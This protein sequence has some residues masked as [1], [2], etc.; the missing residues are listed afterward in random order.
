MRIP[1]G[2]TWFLLYYFAVVIYYV[3]VNGLNGLS[4]GYHKHLWQSPQLLSRT[5]CLQI[6]RLLWFKRISVSVFFI[7]WIADILTTFSNVNPFSF[8]QS[9]FIPL[10][11]FLLTIESVHSPNRAQHLLSYGT[12]KTC[13]NS[14]LF[15]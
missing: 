9:I 5:Q 10:Q 14:L 13:L 12:C 11:L 8:C 4:Q 15:V 3:P 7:A 2:R 1:F 6:S